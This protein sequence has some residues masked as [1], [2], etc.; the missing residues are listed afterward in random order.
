VPETSILSVDH[1][2]KSYGTANSRQTV[3]NNLSFRLK[4]GECYGLLGPNGAGKTTTLR[5]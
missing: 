1:L 4:K 2:Y 5:L 3:I